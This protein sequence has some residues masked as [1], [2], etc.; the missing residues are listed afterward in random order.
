MKKIDPAFVINTNKGTK[1]KPKLEKTG[2]GKFQLQVSTNRRVFE[3]YKQAK[4]KSS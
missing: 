2:S 4:K 1:T 3:I